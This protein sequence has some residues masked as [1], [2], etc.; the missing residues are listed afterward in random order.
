MQVLEGWLNLRLLFPGA[1][2]ID[3]SLEAFTAE[4]WKV[5]G[6]MDAVTAEL[7]DTW[8]RGTAA[9][10][11]KQR[12]YREVAR[13]LASAIANGSVA[14]TDSRVQMMCR[15][16]NSSTRSRLHF[17]TKRAAADAADATTW[18]GSH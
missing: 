3:S 9:D 13:R 10:P 7:G 12:R 16:K 15:L 18:T 8:I 1:K 4:A 6:K 5:R 14:L 2:L 17:E 11:T